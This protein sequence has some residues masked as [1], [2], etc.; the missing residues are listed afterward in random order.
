MARTPP[1]KLAQ[2]ID[3]VRD[4]LSWL[5]DK[6][7]PPHLAAL[8]YVNGLWAFQ[9]VY[10]VAELGVAD[11]LRDGPRSAEQMA[12]SCGVDADALYRLLRGATAVGLFRELDGK[13]FELDRLGRTLCE[14]APASARGFILFQGR[15]GW[16]HWGELLNCVRKDTNAIDLLHG[17]E[18]F[19]YMGSDPD[20]AETF[21]AAMTSATSLLVDPLVAAYDFSTAERIVDVG[22]GR[23]LLLAKILESAPEA[24]GVLFE[25]PDAVSGARTYL[26]DQ[27]LGPRSEVV[28]GDFFDAT[29]IPEGDLYVL[30]AIIHDW[31]DETAGQILSNIRE[32]MP[33]NARVLLCEALLPDANESHLAK[34]TDIEMLVHSDGGRER[35]AEEYRQLLASADLKMTRVVPTAAPYS[36]VEAMLS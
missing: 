8:E 23:G 9:I 36:I 4:G 26:D 21:R 6:L 15:I 30:K 10:V 20:I 27:E 28:G 34:L 12:E 2:F 31:D 19:D 22:G 13:R 14:D 29:S 5:R 33:S 17:M 3:R 18:T 24:H 1:V 11:L 32:V 16:Q 25:L 35:T 7:V